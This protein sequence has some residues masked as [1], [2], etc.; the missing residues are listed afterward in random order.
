MFDKLFG[1]PPADL[2]DKRWKIHWL[3][4]FAG[5]GGVMTIILLIYLAWTISVAQGPGVLH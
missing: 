1:E 2:D 5:V 3:A 4:A